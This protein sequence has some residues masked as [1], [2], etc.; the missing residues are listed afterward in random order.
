MT[1]EKFL[2]II[3]SLDENIYIFKD[4]DHI[5]VVIFQLSPKFSFTLDS[6]FPGEIFTLTGH[7]TKMNLERLLDEDIINNCA[8]DFLLFNLDLFIQ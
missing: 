8:K 6:Q 1:F 5:L 3:S 4:R 7:T 2:C